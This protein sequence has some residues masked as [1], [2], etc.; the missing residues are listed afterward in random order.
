MSQPAVELTQRW[1]SIMDGMPI[2]QCSG[3]IP[4]KRYG[5]L[6]GGPDILVSVPVLW[7]W[8]FSFFVDLAVLGVFKTGILDLTKIK[9]FTK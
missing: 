6:Y 7:I 5:W 3:V 1:P 9:S 2:Q 8:A 4:A